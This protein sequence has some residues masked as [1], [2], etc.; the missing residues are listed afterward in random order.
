M[1]PHRMQGRHKAGALIEIEEGVKRRK[2]RHLPLIPFVL[3]HLGRMGLGAQAL[4]KLIHRDPS[5]PARSSAITATY[6]SIACTLQIGN[7]ALLSNAGTLVK[8]P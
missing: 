2:Y 5:M 1:H 7:V 3:S 6:Q 8:P 4:I